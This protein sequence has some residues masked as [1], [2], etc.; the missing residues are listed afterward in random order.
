V[1]KPIFILHLNSDFKN[2][3]LSFFRFICWDGITVN[4]SL[5]DKI[6]LK[7]DFGS[8]LLL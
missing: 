2:P 3:S 1:Y 8:S 5:T 6:S 7:F 4:L